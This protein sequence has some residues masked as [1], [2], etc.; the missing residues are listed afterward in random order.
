MQANRGPFRLVAIA[1]SAGGL[2]AL[3]TVLGAMP[4]DCAL[5]IVVV[6]HLEPSR[7]SLLASILSRHTLLTVREVVD[8]EVLAA[9]TVHIAPPGFH[10]EVVNGAISL[11]SSPKEHFVRPAADR[12]FASAAEGGP[13][14]AVVLTGSGSDG[15]AGVQAVKATGGLVI[16]QDQATAEFGGMPRAAAET[17]TADYILPLQEIGPLLA[18]L[19]AHR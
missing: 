16:V 6:Q 7:K 3:E 1:T 10:T 5:P 17:L 15:A 8:G 11:T 9:G 19:T 4:A 12:L 14:V 18:A 13:I 2:H